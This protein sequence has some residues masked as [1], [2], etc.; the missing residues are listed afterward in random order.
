LKGGETLA[1][2]NLSQ[3]AN[4]TAVAA[5]RGERGAAPASGNTRGGQR[6]EALA[7]GDKP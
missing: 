3:L 6:G 7:Q 1:S 2:S 5:G 4:G